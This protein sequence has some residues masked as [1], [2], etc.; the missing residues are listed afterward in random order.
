MD[1]FKIDFPQ[2][3]KLDRLSL[4]LRVIESVSRVEFQDSVKASLIEMYTDYVGKDRAAG[5][6]TKLIAQQDFFNYTSDYALAAF[7]ESEQVALAVINAGDSGYYLSMLHVTDAHRGLGVGGELIKILIDS[8]HRLT[9]HISIYQADIS[10]LFE[11]AG[12]KPI[13]KEVVELSGFP[14]LLYKMEANADLPLRE[15]A[16]QY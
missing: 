3:L 12:F 7:I 11:E 15:D 10:K 13:G 5:L 6:V 1:R 8:R 16:L 4:D 2:V 9:A 14:F